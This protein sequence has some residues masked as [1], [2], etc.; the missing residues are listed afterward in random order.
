MIKFGAGHFGV[1]L[2]CFD[3]RVSEYLAHA[4]YRH[5]LVESHHSEGVPAQMERDSLADT[6]FFRHFLYTA[7]YHVV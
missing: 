6:T 7:V 1:N 4:F 2:G 5:S 3:V